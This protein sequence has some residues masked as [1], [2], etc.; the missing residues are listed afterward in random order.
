MRNT[1]NIS[2]TS[3]VC[4]SCGY[5]NYIQRRQNSLRT[6]GHIKDLYYPSCKEV[7]KQYEV[8]DVNSFLAKYS[9]IDFDILDENTQRVISYL[10]ERKRTR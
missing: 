9:N 1:N 10:K 6:E 8:H 7:T 5:V 3:L 4:L 2:C